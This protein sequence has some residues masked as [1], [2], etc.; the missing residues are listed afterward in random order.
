MA[1]KYNFINLTFDTYDCEGWFS[2][3]EDEDFSYKQTINQIYNIIS[4]NKSWK[5]IQTK[6]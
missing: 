1:P 6:N 4:A 5:F 2:E 3:D